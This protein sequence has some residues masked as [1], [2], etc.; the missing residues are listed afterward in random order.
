MTND[1]N[2]TVN[3]KALTNMR[4][5][6][7]I[8]CAFVAADIASIAL[9]GVFWMEPQWSFSIGVDTVSLM[10]CA[11][12]FYSVMHDSSKIDDHNI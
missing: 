6:F 2:S 7:G 4:I 1:S 10:A 3:K 8:I 11:I 5:C 12:L 9:I